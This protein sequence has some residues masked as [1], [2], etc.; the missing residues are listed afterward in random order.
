MK[1]SLLYTVIA[2]VV[3]ASSCNVA[4]RASTI[5]TPLFSGKNELAVTA[6][7]NNIQ[8]AY[9]VSDHVGVMANGFFEQSVVSNNETG[10]GGTGYMGE[11]GAGYFTGLTADPNFIF[12]TYAGAGFGYLYLNNNYRDD[13]SN[14]QKRTLDADGMKFFI[15][16]AIG[17][18]LSYVE[19]SGAIRYSNINYSNIRLSNWPQPELRDA[20]LNELNNS[21]HFIEPGLTLRV[22]LKNIKLQFQ[23]LYCIKLNTEQINYDTDVFSLGVIVKIRTSTQ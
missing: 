10:Q 14:I 21:F 12:E 11:L 23:Y 3:I 6:A 13:N 22:G 9:A 19:V 8:A 4:Y 1:H 18:R 17:Y 2:F 5:N 16:P 15:Q 7:S 20:N